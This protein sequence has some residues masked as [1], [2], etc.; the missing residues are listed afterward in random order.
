MSINTRIIL[1]PDQVKERKELFKFKKGGF[2][3]HETKIS[4]H[5][6]NGE[7]FSIE[8]IYLIYNFVT[9]GIKCYNTKD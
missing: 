4:A 3:S 6:S 7:H 8:K 5:K 1:L 2:N 9:C